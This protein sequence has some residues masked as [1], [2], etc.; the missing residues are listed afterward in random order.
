M[1]SLSENQR[2][3]I[4]SPLRFR[5]NPIKFMDIVNNI[6]C[7]MYVSNLPVLLF[8][9][10]IYLNLPASKTLSFSLFLD[11]TLSKHL[12]WLVILNSGPNFLHLSTSNTHSLLYVF[13]LEPQNG[14]IISRVHF[15]KQGSSEKICLVL[16]R[17]WNIAKNVVVFRLCDNLFY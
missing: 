10:K 13:P 2:L 16:F 17:K 3:F 6:W 4:V 7:C 5:P 11:S 15:R 14:G 9:G 12:P 1:I 8:I